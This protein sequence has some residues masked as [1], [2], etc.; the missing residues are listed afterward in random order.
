MRLKALPNPQVKKAKR[1][2]NAAKPAD[3]LVFYNQTDR[4]ALS[5]WRPK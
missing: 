3:D 1:F 4:A 5:T 2:R